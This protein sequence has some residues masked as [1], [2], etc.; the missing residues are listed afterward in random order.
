MLPERSSGTRYS[1]FYIVIM[2]TIRL[3]AS[4][5]MIRQ[6]Q[7]KIGDPNLVTVFLLVEI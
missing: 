5:M 4:Q 7:R 1:V 3:N 6:G 2:G